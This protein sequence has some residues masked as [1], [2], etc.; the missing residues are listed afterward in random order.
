MQSQLRIIEI[1]DKERIAQLEA[2]VAELEAIKKGKTSWQI[3]SKEIE[4]KLDKAMEKHKEKHQV[5]SAITNILGKAFYRNSVISMTDQE[6]KDAEIFINFAIDF[7]EIRRR[8]YKHNK[9]IL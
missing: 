6:C 2:R 8:E 3:L 5:K 1:S 4:N 9:K 7:I